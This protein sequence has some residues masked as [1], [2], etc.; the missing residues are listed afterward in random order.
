M[1][2]HLRRARPVDGAN[3]AGA[4]HRHRRKR[5]VVAIVSATIFGVIWL[6]SYW[7]SDMVTAVVY[8]QRGVTIVTGRGL[9]V[10]SVDV[11]PRIRDY[12]DHLLRWSTFRC[13]TSS[14]AVLIDAC[15]SHERER[16]YM[17]IALRPEHLLAAINVFSGSLHD[18]HQTMGPFISGPQST[19]VECRLVSVPLAF[20][21]IVALLL[22]A[23]DTAA[24]A[25]ECRRSM[26][27]LCLRCGY[28]LR[29]TPGR[30][31]ECGNMEKPENAVTP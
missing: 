16:F 12:Q 27:G 17:K 18:E 10:F 26:N 24:L 6:I 23:I 5:I 9:A 25:I 13:P 29:A 22:L 1:W 30:C 19:P 3:N 28:D 2:R 31:P 4:T 15:R 11:K 14:T 21:E 20:F 8:R 7:R